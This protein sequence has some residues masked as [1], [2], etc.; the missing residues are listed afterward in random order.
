MG[1]FARTVRVALRYRLTV[2]SSVVCA[3]IV[4]ALWG[5]NISFLLPLVEVV[6]HNQSLS[7]RL[8]E[9]ILHSHKS[10]ATSAEK[11][12]RLS[13]QMA[14]TPADDLPARRQLAHK[15]SALEV[16]RTAT[17]E[18]LTRLEW[19]KPW[20]DDYLPNDPFRT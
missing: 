5:A 14:A 18:E 16:E 11:E 6:A 15:L 19:L 10:L 7:Q 1:N 9:A 2:A 3:L 17:N 4:A 8:D 12:R 20:I 13:E